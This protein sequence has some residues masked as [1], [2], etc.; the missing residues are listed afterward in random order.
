MH[1]KY[2]SLRE[3]GLLSVVDISHV[4][5]TRQ[6]LFGV[7]LNFSLL[8]SFPFKLCGRVVDEVE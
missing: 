7:C 1:Y 3:K 2:F 8:I 4:K 6:Y 5:Y